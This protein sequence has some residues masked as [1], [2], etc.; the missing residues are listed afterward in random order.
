MS[1]DVNN[2][3]TFIRIQRMKRIRD[4]CRPGKRGRRNKQ[5]MNCTPTEKDETLNSLD[6]S[7]LFVFLHATVGSREL[8]VEK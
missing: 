8:A 4:I 2:S 7:N 5:P 1:I 3:I 6:K